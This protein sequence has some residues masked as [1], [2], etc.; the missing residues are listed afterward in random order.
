MLLS[1]VYK[2][3]ESNESESTSADNLVREHLYRKR[4]ANL[5]RN[6]NNSN[7]FNPICKIPQLEIKGHDTSAPGK[8]NYLEKNLFHLKL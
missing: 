8:T 1:Q 5:N 7:D 6:N 3:P 2:Q 4:N